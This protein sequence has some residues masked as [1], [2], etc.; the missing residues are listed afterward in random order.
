MAGEIN[1]FECSK[2]S[3][4]TRTPY[5]THTYA[6]TKFIFINELNTN[7]SFDIQRYAQKEFYTQVFT[8]LIKQKKNI[9]PKSDKTIEFRALIRKYLDNYSQMC[10]YSPIPLE[11]SQQIEN[12]ECAKIVTAYNNSIIL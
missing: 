8:L 3:Y 4:P 6:L 5:I 2:S 7:D 11:Y 12:Y 10:G 1:T 9:P